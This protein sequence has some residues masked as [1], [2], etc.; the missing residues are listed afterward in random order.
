M[1]GN[2]RMVEEN[3]LHITPFYDHLTQAMRE[4]LMLLDFR[5]DI[6]ATNQTAA[7]LLG[8]TPALLIGNSVQDILSPESSELVNGEV[9]NHKT[10]ARHKNG[11]SIPVSMTLMPVLAEIPGHKLLSLTNLVEAAQLNESLIRAQRLAGIG[12]LTASVAHELNNPIS[13]IT[14]TCS[15]LL[16][17]AESQSLDSDRL[18]KFIQVIEQSAWRCARIV[19]VLRNYSFEDS[20]RMAVTDWNMI[21]EDALILVRHQLQGHF[22]VKIEVELAPNLKTIVCDH[23]RMTQV[24]INLLT[25]ARDAMQPDGGT[26]F[27]KSWTIPIPPNPAETESTGEQFAVSITDTGCGIS[28]DVENR[29]FDP[30]FTTKP[31][32]KGMGLGLFIAKRIVNQH[33]G[34]ISAT[35]NP[36]GGATFTV[37]LPQRQ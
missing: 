25:N 23:N 28:P 29:L 12:I 31:M 27:V 20:P 8:Y 37:I 15:N 21:I 30:F 10:W 11:R 4:G 18:F 6:I 13:I 24:L 34:S 16:Y 26:I 32:G 14:A 33:N 3:T 1:Q 35:N 19:E 9:Y 2:G 22:N 17:E 5:G 36:E 7:D